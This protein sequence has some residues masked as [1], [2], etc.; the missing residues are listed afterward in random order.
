VVAPVICAHIADVEYR[1]TLPTP[2]ER[3]YAT[4]PCRS[5]A[6]VVVS[7]DQLL[8]VSTSSH[9]GAFIAAVVEPAA[10]LAR[11]NESLAAYQP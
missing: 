1:P 2:T 8:A 7:V 11:L 5:A 9:Q 3:R 4:A 10:A 6:F